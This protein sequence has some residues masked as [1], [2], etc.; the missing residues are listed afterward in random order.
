ME[1][2]PLPGSCNIRMMRMTHIYMY[3][4]AAVAAACM[5]LATSADAAQTQLSD[6]VL[7]RV[8]AAT[9]YLVTS[10]PGQDETV[11]GSGFFLADDGVLLTN[12]HVV[13]D[14]LAYNAK[15][16]A[17]RARLEVIIFSG[18][19]EARIMT[20]T[21]VGLA[22][23]PA[24]LEQ[25]AVSPHDLALVQVEPGQGYSYLRIGESD[26]LAETEPVYAVGYPLSIP[27]I[28]IREGA[29]SA[30]RHDTAGN[31][32]YIEHTAGLDAG[33]SGGPLIN[34]NGDVVG[35]NTWINGL[36]ANTAISAKVI[37]EYL[38]TAGVLYESAAGGAPALAMT[39]S[40]APT[41]DAAPAAEVPA[42]QA[43][44]TWALAPPGTDQAAYAVQHAE[45]LDALYTR[46]EKSSYQYGLYPG[47]ALAVLC[48]ETVYGDRECWLRRTYWDAYYEG[49]E[50]DPEHCPPALE[51]IDTALHGLSRAMEEFDSID[52]VLA[53]YWCG[54]DGEVN[55]D[56]L[57]R[58]KESVNKLWEALAPE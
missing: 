58:F 42:H 14:L 15:G 23:D 26:T 51:D 16:P 38:D 39:V 32:A 2:K 27:E 37:K 24:L 30:L 44:L 4:I 31:L 52:H 40:P 1:Q 11:T 50:P 35:I 19:D 25:G 7:D 43:V 57:Y 12:A 56:T 21:V 36:Y 54:P 10:F 20:G 53:F 13:R 5:V 55:I 48:S 3:V 8:K 22:R 34:A 29:V 9:A 47:F 28:C 41:A 33:N 45:A 49:E 18:P 17:N 46:I 6:R